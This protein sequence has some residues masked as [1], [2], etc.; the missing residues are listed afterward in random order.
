MQ[1]VPPTGYNLRNIGIEQWLHL[2]PRSGLR[3]SAGHVTAGEVLLIA[4]ANCQH[5]LVIAA[6]TRTVIHAHAGLRR[7]V[8]QPLDASWQIQAKWRVTPNSEG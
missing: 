4:L 3:P 7:V 8:R 5:H 6:D 1:A 2:A